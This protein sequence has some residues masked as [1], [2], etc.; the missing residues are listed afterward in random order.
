MVCGTVTIAEEQANET[1]VD[2]KIIAE[3]TKIV[4]DLQ[5]AGCKS[6][7]HMVPTRL[8][9]HVARRGLDTKNRRAVIFVF[10]CAILREL[11]LWYSSVA[12]IWI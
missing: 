3:H 12:E 5:M 9:S 11:S 4:L 8:L 1:N 10:P 7:S 6:G 2:T